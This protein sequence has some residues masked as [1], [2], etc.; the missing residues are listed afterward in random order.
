MEDLVK[1]ADAVVAQ[2]IAERAERRKA[3]FE[4]VTDKAGPAPSE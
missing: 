2:E 1:A 3:E 4:A